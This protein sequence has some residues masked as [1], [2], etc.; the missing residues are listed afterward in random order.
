MNLKKSTVDDKDLEKV[1]GGV[2]W[3]PC[4]PNCGKVML[5]GAGVIRIH[6]EGAK[7]PYFCTQ[8]AEKFLNS[9][10]A[11]IESGFE[12]HYQRYEKSKDEKTGKII[13]GWKKI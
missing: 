7:H 12:S 9:G 11:V 8:C 3:K 13:Y 1:S 5:G 2:V 6:K 10:E 4:C